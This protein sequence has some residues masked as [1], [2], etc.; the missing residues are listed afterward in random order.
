MTAYS[1]EDDSQTYLFKL[2]SI[3]IL[4]IEI[5]VHISLTDCIKIGCIICISCMLVRH[6]VIDSLNKPIMLCTNTCTVHNLWP[7]HSLGNP[8][9]VA[10]KIHMIIVDRCHP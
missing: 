7:I 5:F 6:P 1:V 4:L 2:I 8:V 3:H 10:A 9:P